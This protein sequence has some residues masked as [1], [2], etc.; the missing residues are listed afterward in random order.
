MIFASSLFP[1]A[2]PPM[3]SFNLG[4]LG[5][6]TPFSV[7]EYAVTLGRLLTTH[8][9]AAGSRDFFFLLL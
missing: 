4:S 6:L 5:F 2:I 1:F 3:V 9:D 7:G 8:D